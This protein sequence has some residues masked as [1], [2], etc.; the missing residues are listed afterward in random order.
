MISEQIVL[1]NGFKYRKWLISSIWLIDETLTGTTNP[2][3]SWSGSN[4]NEGVLHLP[5]SSRT[6]ASP[7]DGLV[8]YH[9]TLIGGMFLICRD[10]ISIFYSTSYLTS[11]DF[12]ISKIIII[13]LCRYHGYPWT[14]LA[15]SPYHSSP[16]A[17]LQG[18]IQY[19]YIP[20]ECMFGL[21]ILLLPGHMWGSIGVH[22][23]WA[24]PCF[25]S[26]V[27]HVWFI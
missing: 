3:K 17:G 2:G 16:L 21:V 20:A 9:D 23:L 13:M 1:L 5:Q 18:N 7:S 6:R 22:H 4:A 25:F 26:S 11:Q 27:L 8:S 15:T 14:S 10:A 24:R 12:S 19:P